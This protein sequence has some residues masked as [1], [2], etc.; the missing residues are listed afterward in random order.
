MLE[1]N[2]EEEYRLILLF[3]QFPTSTTLWSA[4]TDCTVFD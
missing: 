3:D 2:R 1:Y 4:C